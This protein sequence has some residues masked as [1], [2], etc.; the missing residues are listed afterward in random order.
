MSVFKIAMTALLTVVALLPVSAA[1][2]QQQR[3]LDVTTVV[4]KEV[5]VE[6]PEG[7]SETTLAD[8]DSV[9]PGERVIYTIT[10]LNV[11]EEPAEN[12]VI[13]NP[14]ADSLVYVAGSASG[15]GM[16]VEFSIDGGSAFAPASE[17]RVI[18]NGIERPATTKD[19][20]HVRWVMQNEL[21]AGGEGKASFAAVLE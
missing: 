4:Q 5:V 19:Y 16:R 6:T 14:I 21:A 17:L 7:N 18:D 8:A 3:P 13:T 1:K 20:T 10:F 2:S 11:G 9:V 15:D 12:V